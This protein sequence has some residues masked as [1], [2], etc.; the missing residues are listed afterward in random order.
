MRVFRITIQTVCVILFIA[1][2]FFLNTNPNAYSFDSEFFLRLNP[3]TGIVTMLA[4]RSVVM[5]LAAF[6]IFFLIATVLFGRF[7]CGFICPMGAMIDFFDRFIFLKMRSAKRRPQIFV[8][9]LK[10]MFLTAILTLSIF[11][12]TFSLF[13]DPISLMTRFM[14]ILV[15]P[16]LKIIG[17]DLLHSTSLISPSLSNFLYSL[18]PLKTPFFYGSFLTLCIASIVFAG[19][20][21]DK[22]F[23]CQY[24]CPTG[25]FFGLVSRFSLFRRKTSDSHCNSCLRCAK[26]CPVRA[27]DEKK[28]SATNVSECIECGIC[29]QLKDSCSSFHIKLP[30][31]NFSSCPDIKRRHLLTGAAGGLLFL[32]VFRANATNKNDNSGKLIRPPGAIPEEK[33]LSRCIGCGECMKVCPTNTLQPCIF[34]DGFSRLYTPKVVPRVAGC[35]EKCSLCGNVCPTGAIRNLTLKEKQFVK[36]GTAVIDRHRCLAWEQNK[37]CLVCDEVCPY[38]AIEARV[39][40]TVKGKFKVPV[41]NEDLC[42][43]CGMCEQH[44]PIFDV[45]AIVVYK[46]GENRRFSGP[47]MT[48]NQKKRMLE[49]RQISDSVHLGK[50]IDSTEDVTNQN[51]GSPDNSDPY[52]NAGQNSG[53]SDG[54]IE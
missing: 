41:I 13:F 27:I 26:S 8:Q 54:F 4:S 2:F 34:T 7:F 52:G 47:Y 16:A 44:C 5:P 3:L 23:W 18:H 15:N 30:S 6:T 20:F 24:I 31:S 12:V 33:F 39:V 22:R 38:N 43:G 25:A 28:V 45:A 32:P 40:E 9:R 37:E 53:F 46:F 35:E 51:T 36:I 42:L 1:A 17:I 49:R 21:W 50:T 11:G 19:S 10:Y 48:E 29:V 14:T